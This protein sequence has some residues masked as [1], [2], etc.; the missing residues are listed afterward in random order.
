MFAVTLIA[1]ISSDGFISRDKGVPWDLP[2]D[3]AH[4]RRCTAGKWLLL[5]RTTYEEML[6]GWFKDHTPLVLSRDE[7]WRPPLGRRVMS[8][9]QAIGLTKEA[10]ET[11]LVVCGGRVA[12][13]QAMPFATRLI[14][15]R[16]DSALGAGVPFPRFDEG[17]WTLVT[18]ERHQG[19]PSFTI[20]R[21]EKRDEKARGNGLK[22]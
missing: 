12:F 18:T 10:G 16:V 11:E 1:A 8:A 7:K 20:E 13:E 2:A 21:L 4:Y 22:N 5:G 15:T 19:H 9:E 6:G 3:R 14:L 17:G